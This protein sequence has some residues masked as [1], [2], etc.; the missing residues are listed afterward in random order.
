MNNLVLIPRIIDAGRQPL[1]DAQALRDLP[2]HQNA[3]I[4]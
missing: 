4:R 3:R 1:S 2:Q